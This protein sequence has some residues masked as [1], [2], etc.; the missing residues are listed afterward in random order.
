[1]KQFEFSIPFLCNV[2]DIISL[3]L[4]CKTLFAEEEAF[5]FM[6]MYT[7]REIVDNFFLDLFLKHRLF[8]YEYPE[9][10]HDIV[11]FFN[12]KQHQ[13][14]YSWKTRSLL[15]DLNIQINPQRHVNKLFFRSANEFVGLLQHMHKLKSQ[16]KLKEQRMNKTLHQ[17][18]MYQTHIQNTI[19]NYALKM[20]HL[21]VLTAGIPPMLSTMQK[22]IFLHDGRVEN[23]K[24][25]TK[26][27]CSRLSSKFSV[28]RSMMN[29]LDSEVRFLGQK[30]NIFRN[31][32]NDAQYLQH[33]V[34]QKEKSYLLYVYNVNKNLSKA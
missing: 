31:A 2:K 32:K 6:F 26:K 30:E 15:V 8:D 10:K 24:D 11:Q 5:F 4:T 13:S 3:S 12:F 9:V 23:C 27:M 25:E 16:L 22:S 28:V 33:I 1:M 17:Y 34:R 29:S 7:V 20:K 14:R 19:S 18:Q 21:N